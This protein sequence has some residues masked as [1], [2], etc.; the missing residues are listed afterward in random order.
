LKRIFTYRS[1][2]LPLLLLF[3]AYTTQAQKEGLYWYFGVNAGLS[4]HEGSPQPLTN[5]A[6]S[7]VEG[8]SS[9]SSPSGV[10]QFYTDGI[11]VYNRSHTTMGYGNGLM[12]S[13]DAT[14]SGVIVTVPDD[15]TL[16]Y[17]FTV[18]SLGAGQPQNGFRY[19]VVDMDLGGGMGQ[20][21]PERKNILLAPKTTERVTSV[22]HRNDYGIWVIMHE[23]ESSTFRSYLV[24][25]DPTT[26]DN[27]VISPVGTYHGPHHGHK[28]DG[29]GYMKVS[30]EGGKLAVAVMGRNYVEL[31]DFND[32]TGLVDNPLILPVDTMPYGVEFS[33]FGEYLYCSERKGDKI[34]QW[35][36][37]AGSNEAIINSRTVVGVLENPFG[38]AMQL[39]SDGRI[40]IARK[41]KFYLSRIKFPQKKG[42]DCEFEEFGVDL[43]GKQSKE[44]L[45]TFVQS[46]FNNIWINSEYECIDEEIEFSINSII[47]IDS[48]QWDF[49]DPASTSNSM[50]GDSV[51]HLFTQ[52]GTYTV[53]ATCYHLVTQTVLYKTVKIL[54][55]PDVELGSDQTICEG[56]TITIDAGDFLTYKWNN[57]SAGIIP[58]YTTSKEEQV[59]VEVTNTCGI[60][61]DTVYVY[62]RDLP[63]VDLGADTAMYFDTSID[64]DAGSHDV[65]LW[66]DGSDFSTYE[67]DFPGTFWVEVK[68]ELGCTSSDTIKVEPIPFKIHVPTAFSPNGDNVND[69]FEV[70]TSY[71]AD[72]NFEMMIF[73]RWGEQVFESKSIGEF[74][75]GTWRGEPCP[76]ETYVWLIETEGYEENVF[77]PGPTKMT[78]TV[79]LLR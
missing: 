5:G 57:G 71:E 68:D 28:R 20:V 14:Q 16:Y 30:P 46:Y 2:L 42:L 27:P 18:S 21:I 23:W 60:D 70:F 65:Y 54:P 40:Y 10:L 3:T 53:T 12:G 37:L 52:A 67:V 4:F 29:I 7:T 51:S 44:G 17:I 56:D 11:K 50:W 74:W 13:P 34:Y 32:S 38:G 78:G 62:I 45:P 8:C 75:D 58:L 24:T 69:L 79:S 63:V 47:N 1:F 9:I 66:Q 77:F 25:T 35:D 19:S 36:M 22:H 59:T 41:S 15:T 31:F 43:A 6:L 26:L 73:N 76:V 33:A 72:I 61:F 49:G 39:A 48:I 55:L 64:L